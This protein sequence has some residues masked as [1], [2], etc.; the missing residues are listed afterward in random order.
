M[1]ARIRSI[2]PALSSTLAY[3]WAPLTVAL[4]AIAV[5]SIW[6]QAPGR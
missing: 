2:Y 4:T 3:S 5:L 6:N 1:F